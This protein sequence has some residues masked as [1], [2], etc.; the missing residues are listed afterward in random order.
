MAADGW[1]SYVL[2]APEHGHLHALQRIAQ[3]SSG[4][5]VMLDL[6]D[7]ADLFL[8]SSNQG[9]TW[10][11]R[12]AKIAL[13]HAGIG[14]SYAALREASAFARLIA[15]NQVGPESRAPV[16]ALLRAGLEAFA[17]GIRPDIVYFKCL[18]RFARD[19]GY[20]VKQEWFPA[21]R[22]KN[23]R[24]S[25]SSST[26]PWSNRPPRPRRW[27]DCAAFGRLFA[28]GNRD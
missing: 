24:R 2:F 22:T 5:R 13:R 12:E 11:V 26:K 10:F 8:E 19:E 23:A 25:P 15:L 16:A 14:H 21:C 3:K 6:F 7:E 27:R 28:P 4:T 9:R 17:R 1:Q 18:Y 20:P